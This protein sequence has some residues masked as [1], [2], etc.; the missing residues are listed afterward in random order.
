MESPSFWAPASLVQPLSKL[1]LL[2]FD[3]PAKKS[4]RLM[5]FFIFVLMF[6][7]KYFH[8]KSENWVQTERLRMRKMEFLKPENSSKHSAITLMFAALHLRRSLL[9]NYKA[10]LSPSAWS[11]WLAA[12]CICNCL[13]WKG[14]A[15]FNFSTEIKCSLAWLN[16]IS[17]EW[18]PPNCI[19]RIFERTQRKIDTQRIESIFRLQFSRKTLLN[20][21]YVAKLFGKI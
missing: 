20:A 15:A 14:A 19:S 7:R 6:T 11:L 8:F 10:W 5:R 2:L 21:K 9:E 1:F 16:R 3:V 12:T 4:S 17:L 18:R 13:L